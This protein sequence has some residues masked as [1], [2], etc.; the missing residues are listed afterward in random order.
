MSAWRRPSHGRWSGHVPSTQA[1]SCVPAELT[2]INRGVGL[3]ARAARSTRQARSSRPRARGGP[4]CSTA[5][6]AGTGI[7]CVSKGCS[8]PLPAK[9][10]RLV[11]K[12]AIH[13]Q[14]I[15][16]LNITQTLLQSGLQFDQSPCQGGPTSGY[17]I[18]PMSLA[19]CGLHSLKFQVRLLCWELI[20]KFLHS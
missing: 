1:S 15:D 17:G 9:H 2:F 8:M 4:D 7:A 11:G 13:D 3:E 19:V 10:Q 18:A 16:G 14:Y 12:V 20:G 5:V 6:T